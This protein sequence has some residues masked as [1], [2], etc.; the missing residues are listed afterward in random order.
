MQLDV[1]RRIQNWRGKSCMLFYESRY[2]QEP[3][4]DPKG[5]NYR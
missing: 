2:V 1:A 3:K 4:F 5:W